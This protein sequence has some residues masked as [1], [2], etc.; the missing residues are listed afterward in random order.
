MPSFSVARPREAYI[1]LVTRHRRSVQRP[2][3]AP[4]NAMSMLHDSGSKFT[5]FVKL[6]SL[7]DPR[8]R[9]C[10]ALSPR[11]RSPP[12]PSTKTVLPATDRVHDG[13]RAAASSPSATG[14]RA[15]LGARAGFTICGRAL[16]RSTTSR[17]RILTQTRSASLQ[18]VNLA[19]FDASVRSPSSACAGIHNR[20]HDAQARLPHHANGKGPDDQRYSARVALEATGPG[21]K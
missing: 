17:A 20:V 8:P 16:S 11:K 13:Q 9:R 15:C 18:I 19:I 7:L 10:D 6:A 12:P 14:L 21:G 1:S 4:R 2:C 5:L 3:T